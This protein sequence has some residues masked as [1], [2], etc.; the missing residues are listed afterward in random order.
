MSTKLKKIVLI[1]DLH[2]GK[3]SLVRRFMSNFFKD[4]LLSTIGVKIEKKEIVINDD[5]IKLMIWDLA[6][7]YLDKGIY[8]SYLKGAHGAIAVFDCSRPATYKKIQKVLNSKELADLPFVLVAN[9]SDLLKDQ[10]YFKNNYNFDFLTS[11]KTGS[12]VETMFKF[13]TEKII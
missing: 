3:T 6:G 1:G 12:D 2:V 7:E 11:A 5:K 10:V 4:D 9:K 13:I 8:K